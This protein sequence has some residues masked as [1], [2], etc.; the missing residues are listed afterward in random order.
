M[1]CNQF[2]WTGKDLTQVVHCT[3]VPLKLSILS[4]VKTRKNFME[5][6]WYQF[7]LDLKLK[8]LL[9]TLG[10]S[11]FLQNRCPI[12]SAECPCEN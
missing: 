10:N 8:Y 11:I 9:N 5:I 6:Y 12:Y 4:Y 3:K 1:G 7:F 2:F